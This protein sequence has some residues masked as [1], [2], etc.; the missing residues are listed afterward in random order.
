MHNHPLVHLLSFLIL[1]YT[2]FAYIRSL[3]V[4][5]FTLLFTIVNEEEMITIPVL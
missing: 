3:H 2:L 4:T 5:C 1:Y